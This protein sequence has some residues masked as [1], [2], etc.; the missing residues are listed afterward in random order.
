MSNSQKEMKTVLSWMRANHPGGDQRNAF[1]AG[2]VA[3]LSIL[4]DRNQG[5]RSAMARTL[6]L[7]TIHF[8]SALIMV[9]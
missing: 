8:G 6:I 7:R 9:K 5:R 2:S 4:L 3:G 1:V